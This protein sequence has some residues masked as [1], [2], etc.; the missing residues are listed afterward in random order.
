MLETSTSIDEPPSYSLLTDILSASPDYFYVF[1]F[2]A[3]AILLFISAMVSASEVAFFSLKAEDLDNCRNSDDTRNKHILHLLTNPRMLLATILIMNNFVNVAIVTLSTFLMWEMTS[4]KN[5]AE[6]IVGVVTFS[7]T[8]AITFFGEIIPKVYATQRNLLYA[9]L[10]SGS[11]IVLEKICR[12]VSWMLLNLGNLIESRIKVKGYNTTVEELNRA[13]ELTTEHDE[14]TAEEKDILKGIVNFGTLSVKQIMKSRMDISSVNYELNFK[15]LIEQVTKSGFSRIP[16]YQESL[17]KIEGILY[18]KD[19]LPYLEEGENFKWHKLL[20]PG[21]FI[22]ETKRIDSLLK[23]FQEKRVHMALVVD[24]YGGTSGL[25]TL[26][27]LIEEIIGEIN[28]EF[29]EET[30]AFTRIDDHTFLFEGRTSLHDFCK[31]I[32]VEPNA[33]DEVRG[34]SESLGG[35]ILELHSALPNVGENITFERFTFTVVAV[36]EKRIKRVRVNIRPDQ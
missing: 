36:D 23:D 25:I 3:I 12:P 1:S 26:E 27:D 5:P 31:L 8:F 10:I 24:E 18:I 4:T 16:V 2:A 34:E 6:V 15:E 28:D 9:R 21:F 13:L 22:P 19:L 20:R 14:T 17:D 11:W 29:D 7:V 32:E 33:F 35:L 30:K